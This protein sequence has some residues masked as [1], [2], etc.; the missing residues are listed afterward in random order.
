[1]GEEEHSE[2]LKDE[3]KIMQ[4]PLDMQ[5]DVPLEDPGPKTATEDKEEGVAG[6]LCRVWGT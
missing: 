2:G 3:D 6:Q 1:M 5:E 4:V